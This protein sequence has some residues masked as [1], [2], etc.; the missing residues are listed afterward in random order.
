MSKTVVL[1]PCYNEEVAI[2]K[3][4]ADFKRVLPEAEI[5][6]YDNNSTDNSARIAAEAGATVVPVPLQGKGNVVR[7]M[8]RDI[9]AD[10]YLMVDSDDTYPAEAARDLIA[11][12]LDG[13]MDMVTGD[14][15]S[16]T[17]YNI[18]KRKFHNFGN[19]LVCTMIRVLFKHKVSD[20]MTGYRAFSRRFCQKFS[21]DER[22]F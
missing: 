14:R 2:G 13:G 16:T 4:I 17:Y 3:V 18:N 21:G 15:L 1:L 7:N 10:C 9:E 8:F 11:P 19:F 5:F 20:V 6:V 12:V 22:R